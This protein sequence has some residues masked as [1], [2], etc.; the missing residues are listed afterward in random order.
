MFEFPP[1]TAFYF[2]FFAH[3]IDGNPVTGLQDSDFTKK[4]SIDGGAFST[5]GNVITEL[6]EGWYNINFSG[7]S[8][9]SE[10]LVAIYLTAPGIM[11]VNIMFK[12]KLPEII[13][14][15][16]SVNGADDAY[17]L[18]L[19]NIPYV[20]NAYTGYL[21][22]ITDQ[23]TGAAQIAFIVSHDND[24]GRTTIEYPS[25]PIFTPQVDDRVT[26]WA[27][28]FY[29]SSRIQKDIW[30]AQRSEH[31]ETGSFGE[32]IKAESLNTQA[33][34]DVQTEA[35]N[36]LNAYDPP[37]KAELDATQSA[38]ESA[39]SAISGM[40]PEEVKAALVEA[41][42]TDTYADPTTPPPDPAS[43]ADMIKWVFARSVGVFIQ[44]A[45]S[46]TLRN[47]DDSATIAQRTVTASPTQAKLDEWQP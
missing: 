8:F 28:P 23:A 35:T 15:K 41:L 4:R 43:L 1:L 10:S 18:Y 6:E 33:K 7:G 5:I 11:Q 3:D 13:A 29:L 44:D 34:A 12:I 30:N 26:I 20:V 40:T 38:L 39:I 42:T 47:R 46:Q 24:E 32:G 17:N 31:T 45:V 14:Q 22:S 36:A 21:I 37:T 25:A 16:S 2:P 27:L 9:P 19:N